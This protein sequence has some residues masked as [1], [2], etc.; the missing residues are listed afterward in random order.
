MGLGTTGAV[1]CTHVVISSEVLQKKVE[2]S[3]LQLSSE[4]WHP[5]I[6]SNQG[7]NCMLCKSQPSHPSTTKHQE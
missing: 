1:K 3:T 2:I 5:S 7:I 6:I 4:T